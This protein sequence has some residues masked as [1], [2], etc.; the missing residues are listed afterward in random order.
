MQRTST[1]CSRIPSKN[2]KGLSVWPM[3]FSQSF[4]LS[5][6]MLEDAKADIANWS[7]KNL[8]ISFSPKVSP[9]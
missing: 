5:C 2:G 3:S 9:I 6:K 8:S 7:Q 1:A 4:R